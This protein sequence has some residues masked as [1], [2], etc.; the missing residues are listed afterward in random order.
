MY[1]NNNITVSDHSI[2]SKKETSTTV[3]TQPKPNK[4]TSVMTALYGLTESGN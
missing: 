1:R 4:D 3:T 2:I